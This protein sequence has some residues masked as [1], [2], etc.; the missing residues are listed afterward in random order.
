LPKNLWYQVGV[1]KERIRKSMNLKSIE[2]QAS[3]DSIG[4]YFT[5]DNQVVGI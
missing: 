2:I 5:V 1:K 4:G 3:G